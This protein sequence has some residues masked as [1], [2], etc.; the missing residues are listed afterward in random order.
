MSLAEKDIRKLLAT[1]GAADERILSR[2]AKLAAIF[3]A[4]P[5]RLGSENYI[6]LIPNMQTPMSLKDKAIE[7]LMPRIKIVDSRGVQV[8]PKDFDAV[9]DWMAHLA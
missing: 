6:L 9:P 2:N 7:F 3:L 8:W 1:A 4:Y 5:S